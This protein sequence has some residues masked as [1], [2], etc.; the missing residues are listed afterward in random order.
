MKVIFGKRLRELRRE[1]DITQKCLALDLNVSKTTISQWETAVQYPDLE[2]LATI[3][4]YFDVTTD[5]LLG[6]TD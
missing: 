3:A 2:M 1:A 4:K 6:L 5:Y